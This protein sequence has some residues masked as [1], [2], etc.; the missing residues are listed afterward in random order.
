[1]PP[2]AQNERTETRIRELENLIRNFLRRRGVLEGVSLILP[3]GKN[4]DLGTS[5]GSQISTSTAQKL[6]F[7]GSTP[8]SQATSGD[9]AA[10]SLDL[11][12][13]GGDTVDK[14]AIN[15]NFSAIQTLL[16]RLRLD[17]V[18]KGIIKGL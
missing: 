15:A 16:N 2:N 18:N 11:D 6:A 3:D 12:V 13:T 7:H 17:L 4:L 5:T 10:V 1:M 8:I 14:A 9:Q